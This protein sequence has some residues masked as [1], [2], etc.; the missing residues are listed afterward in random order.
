MT[1]RMKIER[2]E[3]LREGDWA[4]LIVENDL[5]KVT[6]E[7]KVRRRYGHNFVG[8][9]DRGLFLDDPAATL[10][11]A[12]REVPL[13]TEPGLYVAGDDAHHLGYANFYTL[14]SS[15]EWSASQW[16]VP[17]RGEIARTR[18]MSAHVNKGGLVRLVP[19][20]EKP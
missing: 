5:G 13:P 17:V 19:E 2:K 1:N 15:G 11:E 16:M 12:Y 8:G 7:G 3:D 4:K 10:V 9:P 6:C 20:G 14:G 18:A